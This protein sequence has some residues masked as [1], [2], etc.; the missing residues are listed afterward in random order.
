M[1][2]TNGKLWMRFVPLLLVLVLVIAA[3]S[4]DDDPG[5]DPDPDMNNAPTVGIT[6]DDYAMAL[7]SGGGTGGETGGSLEQLFTAT[8]ADVDGDTLSYTWSADEG[9]ELSPTTGESTTATFD[10]PGTFD[11]SVEVN[12]GSGED[13]ATGEDTV[14]AVIGEPGEPVEPDPDPDPD[15]DP[16][17][18]L[19]QTSFG[20]S[21]TAD[22]TFTSDG[23]ADGNIDDDTDP[24]IVDVDATAAGGGTFYL[25]VVAEDDTGIDEVVI[26]L[27]NAPIPGDGGNI[28]KGN[29]PLSTT[30]DVAG[31][32]LGAIQDPSTCALDGTE[33]EVTC[34]Y[35]VTVEQGTPEIESF[36]LEGEDDFD[37]EFAYVFRANVID[38]DANATGFGTRG[39]V[40]LSQ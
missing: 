1:Q 36:D 34:T 24:R 30:E 20:A 9:V 7:P 21:L 39:Y 29:V 8:G 3:C 37:G 28:S 11:I 12:D 31:F 16:T 5:P 6:P 26:Q 17:T 23:G 2:K 38:S 13:N 4:N 19:I 40:D 32:T 22:G 10:T 27:R 15:P 35:E 33:T 25:Q 14:S 18:E